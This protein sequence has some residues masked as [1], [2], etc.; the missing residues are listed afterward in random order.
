MLLI[1]IYDPPMCCSTGICGTDIDPALVG[2]AS[3]LKQLMSAGVKVERDNLGRQPMACVENA[4]VK[5]LLDNDGRR[6]HRT[7]DAV[8]CSTRNG[9]RLPLPIHA[10]PHALA[11]AA[12]LGAPII[13]CDN[14]AD[15]TLKAVSTTLPTC[16]G[17]HAMDR[18][19]IVNAANWE[20]LTQRL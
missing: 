13:G 12:I 11:P 8:Q 17:H 18:Q 10:S 15:A 14:P 19:E 4:S 7:A 6:G 9:M 2:F 20:R 3:L 16:V 5:A 1:K